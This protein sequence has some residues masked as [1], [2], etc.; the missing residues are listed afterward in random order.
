MLRLREDGFDVDALG[1]IRWIRWSDLSAAC[2]SS[3][4]LEQRAA[5]AA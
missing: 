1:A 5:S 3:L 4:R 2:C